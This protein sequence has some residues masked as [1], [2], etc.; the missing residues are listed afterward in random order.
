MT[1]P[2]DPELPWLRP[3]EPVVHRHAR[4]RRQRRLPVIVLLVLGLACLAAGGVVLVRE[5]TRAPTRAEQATALQ[6]EIATRWQRLSAGQVFPATL[7]YQDATGDSVVARRVGIAPPAA[8]RSALEP[9]AY[10]QV[11]GLGCVTILRA[12][13]VGAGGALASTV[14]V[15]VMR[16]PAAAQQARDA[17]VPLRAG[18]GVHAVPFP[19]TITAQFG[20][21][22]RGADSGQAAGPYLVLYTAGFTD[23]LPGAAATVEQDELVA[24]GS[25]LAGGLQTVLTGHGSPCRMKD[26]EC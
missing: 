2:L 21:A 4:R 16:S 14:G 13:Y 22:A 26:I 6:R 11:R 3:P 5:L 8:C 12:T 15:V 1:T 9:G 24:F 20:D 10:Q 17:L 7:S 23:G 25:G 19:G 18:A